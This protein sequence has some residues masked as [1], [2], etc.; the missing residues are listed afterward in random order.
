M[1]IRNA[2]SGE[3]FRMQQNARL[4]LPVCLCGMCCGNFLANGIRA[5]RER[6]S[7]RC[8]RVRFNADE[9]YADEPSIGAKFSWSN[10]RAYSCTFLSPAY[11]ANGVMVVV[12][13]VVAC[14]ISVI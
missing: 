1:H 6:E 3:E 5:R 9:R 13:V 2:K 14:T 4:G 11:N 8:E 12:V 7:A 10:F